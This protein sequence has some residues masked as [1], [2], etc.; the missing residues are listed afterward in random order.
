[1]TFTP[2]ELVA[3]TA[4]QK[5]VDA[6]VL[7]RYEN[8]F[9]FWMYREFKLPEPEYCTDCDTNR[10]AIKHNYPWVPCSEHPTQPAESKKQWVPKL[11]KLYYTPYFN[12][13]LMACPQTWDN[14]RTDKIRLEQGLV[15]QTEEEAREMALKMLAA[16]KK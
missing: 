14:H 1:M 16:I 13:N 10:D 7:S 15:C 4:I 8:D 3:V 6:Y 9:A 11:G 2:Q 12:D 5:L